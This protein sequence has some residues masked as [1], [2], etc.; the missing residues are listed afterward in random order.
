MHIFEPNPSHTINV[1]NPVTGEESIYRCYYKR[2]FTTIY[3]YT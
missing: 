2:D 1:L 3:L